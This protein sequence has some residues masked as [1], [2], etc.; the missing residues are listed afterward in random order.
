[1]RAKTLLN[2]FR[3][4]PGLAALSFHSTKAPRTSADLSRKNIST[5]EH[6]WNSSL[7][8][9]K[10]RD[11]E[12]KT[13]KPLRLSS[14]TAFQTLVATKCFAIIVHLTKQNRLIVQVIDTVINGTDGFTGR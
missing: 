2:T 5:S 8:N 13:L 10:E 14:E 6:L 7:F 1:M 4:V 3:F 9:R 11:R 12:S